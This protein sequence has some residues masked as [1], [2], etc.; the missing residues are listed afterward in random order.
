M[1]NDGLVVSE[2]GQC[3][4]DRI[5]VNGTDHD[6]HCPQSLEYCKECYDYMLI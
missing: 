6:L 4:L 3:V 2:T 5:I 1:C